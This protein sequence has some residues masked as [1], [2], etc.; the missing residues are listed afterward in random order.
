[1]NDQDFPL[2]GTKILHKSLLIKVITSEINDIKELREDD[3]S[4]SFRINQPIST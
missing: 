4:I 2:M 3:F 1:M